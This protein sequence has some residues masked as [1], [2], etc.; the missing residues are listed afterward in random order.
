M[1]SKVLAVLLLAA[2]VGVGC[3]AAKLKSQKEDAWGFVS[4]SVPDSSGHTPGYGHPFRALAFVFHPVGVALDWVLVKPFYMM[5]GAA[6]EWFGLTTD[7]AQ[8][9]QQ[10]YPERVNSRSAPER[11]E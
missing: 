7:D 10:A 11:F 9:F 2:F 3:S 1:R 6:P 5:G 8:R 4:E